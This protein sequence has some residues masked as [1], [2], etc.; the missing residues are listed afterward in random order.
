MTKEKLQELKDHIAHELAFLEDMNKSRHRKLPYSCPECEG[1]ASLDKEDAE[2]VL[3]L[4]N[5]ELSLLEQLEED[6]CKNG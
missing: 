3:E 1:A 6:E 4:I 2:L 5:Q